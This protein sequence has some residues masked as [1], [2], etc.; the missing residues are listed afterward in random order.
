MAKPGQNDHRFDDLRK[1]FKSEGANAALGKDALPKLGLQLVR[2]ARDGV[3]DLVKNKHGT[4]VD[5]ASKLYEE[6]TKTAGKALHDHTPD[7]IKSQVSKMRCFIKAGAHP[8]ATDPEGTMDRAVELLA[9]M[10]AID[11]KAVKSAYAA[12]CDVARAIFTSTT[13]LTD[14]EIKGAISKNGPAD[15]TLVKELRRAEKILNGIVTGDAGVGRHQTA[16][17]LKAL[18]LVTEERV[19]AEGPTPVVTN[20]PIVGLDD[21]EVEQDDGMTVGEALEEAYPMGYRSGDT[22]P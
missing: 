8:Q 11:P 2:A 12:Y 5:D 6:Y 4:G 21:D 16:A 7:S 10:A 14:D 1:V 13:D 19:A 22:A 9:E 17:M 20:A 3:V 18:D 15:K